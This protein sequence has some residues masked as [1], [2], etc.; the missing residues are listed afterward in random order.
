[1]EQMVERMKTVLEAIAR[2]SAQ[3]GSAPDD[4]SEDR[5]DILFAGFGDKGVA[6]GEFKI[7]DD[8]R[9]V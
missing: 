6:S 2:L 9:I 7:W 3:N 4:A 5:L 8:P 1:M